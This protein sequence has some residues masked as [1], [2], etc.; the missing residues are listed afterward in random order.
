MSMLSLSQRYL[1]AGAPDAGPWEAL[2][3]LAAAARRW[4][5]YTQLAA[6]GAWIFLFY[7]SLW[8]FRLVP[9]AL[10]FLGLLGVLLQFTGVTLL[11]FLGFP[12]EGRMAMPLGPIHMAVAVWL[13][14]KSFDGGA[15]LT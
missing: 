5:H 4:A 8:R 1:E 9:R 14:V 10:A 2:G 12:Q 15:E 3:A 13:M 11:T 6:I 7:S